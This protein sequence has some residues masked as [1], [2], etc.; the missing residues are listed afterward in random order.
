MKNTVLLTGSYGGLGSC[1]AKIHAKRGGDL[2][3]VGRSMKKLE[4]QKS[5]L[6]K[7]YNIQI[8]CIEADLSNED[9]PQAIY[10]ECKKNGWTVDYLIK[11]TQDLA[12]RAT[13]QEKEHLSRI[14][15]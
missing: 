6:Q 8:E 14:Y 11:T 13:L 12:V 15:R 7:K 1:L 5:E 4:E 10:D 3:L 9:A 2:I